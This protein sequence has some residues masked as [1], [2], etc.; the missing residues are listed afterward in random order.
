LAPVL[1]TSVAE[2]SERQGFAVRPGRQSQTL[3]QRSREPPA[4][5]PVG[6]VD[7]LAVVRFELPP[8]PESAAPAATSTM[9]VP[10]RSQNLTQRILGIGLSF[11]DAPD[12]LPGMTLRS[13][14]WDSSGVGKQQPSG[15]VTLVF[16]D[17]EGSTR[18]LR[19]LGSEKYGDAL[20]EHRDIVRDAFGARGGYEVDT[21]GDAFFYTFASAVDAV[22]AVS[23]AMTRLEPTP[24]RLRVGVHTGTPA[25][26]GPNYLGLDVHLAARVGAAGH[27]G[28]VLLTGATRELVDVP[29]AG[30]GEHRLKDFDAPIALFQLGDRPFPPLKTISNTNLPHPV[31]SFVGRTRERE[32]LLELL[33][34]DTRLVTLSGPGGSGKTRLALEVASELVPGFNAGVFWIGLA[35]LRDP[36]LVMET[37]AQTIGAKDEL[38]GHIGDRELLLLLDNFEHVVDAAPKLGDLLERCPNL[39]LLV[40][41]RELLRIRG[42][43]DYPVPPLAAPEAV[44]LFCARSGLAPD[45]TVGELCRR[46]DELPLALELA[47][48]RTSVLSVAQILER[49][50]QRLDLLKGGR[51]A[52]A[53]QQTLRATIEWSHDLLTDEEQTLFRRLSVFRGGCSLEAAEDVAGAEVDVLQSLVDKSL[54]RHGDERFWM[55]ETIREYAREQ[56]GGSSEEDDLRRRHGLFFVAFVEEVTPRLD[57]GRAPETEFAPLRREHDNLRATLEWASK[58]GEDE[59]LLR[60]AAGLAAFWRTRGF[61]QE[62]GRWLPLALDRATSP[63]SARIAALLEAARQAWEEDDWPR[64]AALIDEVR[65]LAEQHGDEHHLLSAMGLEAMLAMQNGDLEDARRRLLEIRERSRAGGHRT[66]EAVAVTNLTF[67]A[68]RTGNYQAGRDHGAEAVE[69]YRELRS[70]VGMSEALLM[71]GLCSLH[72]SDPASAAEYFGESVANIARLDAIRT[73]RGGVVL[74]WLGVAHIALR[75]MERGVQLLGAAVAVRTDIESLWNEDDEQALEDAVAAAR[76]SLDEESFATAWN[77]GEALTPEEITAFATA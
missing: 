42:E 12:G 45:E 32:E 21:E 33:R 58:S 66:I 35:S 24:V 77:R 38:A 75:H 13:T 10:R 39:K 40:T 6:A 36:A 5:G 26:D 61:Y 51:D 31:S 19:E 27:G 50:G 46:L 22:A 25:L 70:E 29:V 67:V 4:G 59:V 11:A 54:L 3:P 49:L 63:V 8:Q 20:A 7:V 72:L 53:R 52:E 43:I 57:E 18:L 14:G 55:L 60:L 9:A 2:R 30:L 64:F 15:T 69:V 34:S 16:T 1:E 28:Q 73:H 71:C 62:R 47:A 76:A 65:S 48:T 17:I 44:E 56:L 68:Y 74:L 41:S 37:I 23:E